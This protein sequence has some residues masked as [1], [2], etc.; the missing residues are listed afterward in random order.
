VAPDKQ[1]SDMTA[2][3]A[4][5]GIVSTSNT[6]SIQA[7]RKDGTYTKYAVVFY[8]AGQVDMGDGLIVKS[9]K[10]AIVFIK[11]YPSNYRVSV[12]DPLYTES[13][14]VITLNKELMGTDIV[15]S[16]GES[17]ITFNLPTGDS[18]GS[19]L[20]K[21]CTRTGSGLLASGTAQT[22]ATA[23]DL[24]AADEKIV[25]YPNPVASTL[26]ITG[27]SA[28]ALV[29][30]YDPSGVKYKTARGNTIDVSALRSGVLYSVTISDNGKRTI[31]KF[32][33]Q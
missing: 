16:G 8:A 29:E 33:K 7:I 12:A 17:A 23:N 2:L 28:N 24:T 21:F 19:T 27:V 11:K 18:K 6:T 32:L 31:R 10:K 4:N 30:I 1:A 22:G 13:S 26:K 14:I 25:V 20:T 9:N 3:A 5:H 15:Y